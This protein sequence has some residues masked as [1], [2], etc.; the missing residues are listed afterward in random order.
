MAGTMH[1]IDFSYVRSCT[2]YLFCT[3]TGMSEVDYYIQKQYFVIL[4][5]M[6]FGVFN[7]GLIS[8]LHHHTCISFVTYLNFSGI[9]NKGLVTANTDDFR[10]CTIYDI[11]SFVTCRDMYLVKLYNLC[12]LGL[13][14]NLNSADSEFNQNS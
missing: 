12:E 1:S 11:H 8:Y 10:T 6:L 3:N 4:L 7:I 5:C 2:D 13:K 9:P 14:P